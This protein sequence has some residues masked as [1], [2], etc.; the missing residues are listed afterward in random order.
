[1]GM[2]S[3]SPDTVQYPVCSG[4]TARLNHQNRPQ[5]QTP[6]AIRTAS[7][8][9]PLYSNADCSAPAQYPS[10]RG[11]MPVT[12]AYSGCVIPTILHMRQIASPGDRRQVRMSSYKVCRKRT[13]AVAFLTVPSLPFSDNFKQPTPPGLPFAV[14]DY[15]ELVA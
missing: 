10:A 1:M 9:S 3:V 8:V 14:I 2:T 4:S 13:L 5:Q 12:L 11:A 7:G 6:P 15:I